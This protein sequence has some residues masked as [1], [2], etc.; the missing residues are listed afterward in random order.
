MMD[1]FKVCIDRK[2]RGICKASFLLKT[3]IS[4]INFDLKYIVDYVFSN[5]RLENVNFREKTKHSYEIV[6]KLINA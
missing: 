4:I 3:N 2:L 5:F 1:L 6:P